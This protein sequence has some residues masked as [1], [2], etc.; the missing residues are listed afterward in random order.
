MKIL[1]TGGAGMIGS[2]L[3]RALL[4][5]GFEVI[6]LDKKPCLDSRAKSVTIDLLDKQAVSDVIS[7][8][9]VDK[10]IH[11]AALAHT[12]SGENPTYD[13][14]YRLN[15]ECAKNVFEASDDLDVLFIS[16]VDV[17]GFTKGT[18]STE[19]EIHPVTPYAKTKA[20]AEAQCQNIC[21]KYS[22][23]RLSPVYTA[24]IKRDIQKRYY[25]KYPKIA[26]LIGK[27]TDYEVLNIE[28]AVKKMVDWCYGECDNLIHIIKDDSNLNTA[29]CIKQEKEQ[30]RAKFVLRFPKF[31]IASAY[32][33]LKFLTGENKYTYLI[34]KAVNPLRTK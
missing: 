27:G 17:Y 31:I 10:I 22:I 12:T 14:Y 32:A 6:S 23:F 28:L 15:V 21:S 2:H 1:V 25:L 16:T 20:L 9:N 34:N 19:T 7:H 3:V 5:T 33:V 13:D 29:D 11:L 8:S 30:G 4:D 18:V 24:E 26:Y